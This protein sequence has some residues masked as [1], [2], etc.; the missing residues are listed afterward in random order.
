MKVKLTLI[1]LI[2]TLTSCFLSDYES[3]RIKSSTENFEISATVNRTNKNAKNYAYVIV[4]LFDKNN[5]KL[6]EF[7]TQAGDGH[8]WTIGWTKSGDTI[9]LQSSDIGNKAW[10]L[11]NE[12][13]NEIKM[14]DKLNER[15]EYLYL[16]KYK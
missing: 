16:E 15:A 4:H 10:T 2:L 7:N 12:N 8:K 3:E 1:F 13:P 6:T 5:Q 9:I 14:T 11:Q